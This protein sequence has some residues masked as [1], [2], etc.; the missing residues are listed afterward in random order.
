A[1]RPAVKAV[2]RLIAVGA[3]ILSATTALADPAPFQPMD[4]RAYPI[5]H[6]QIGTRETRFGPLEFVGG[7]SMTSSGRHF[8]ALSSVAFAAP[9]TD[10]VGVAD[11]GF[12]FFG[13]IERDA[14]GRPVGVA[15]FRMQPM[16]NADVAA[17]EGNFDSDAE[18]LDISGD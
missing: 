7:F 9:G 12:W 14:G 2:P 4:I 18:G 1:R 8:G 13:T 5:E 15:N 17:I 16:V 10:F 11:T 3:A 6:F